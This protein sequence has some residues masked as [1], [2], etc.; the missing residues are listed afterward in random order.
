MF[1]G[2]GGPKS[3]LVAHALREW[4]RCLSPDV[5]PWVSTLDL[6]PGGFWP[7]ELA[8]R[9]EQTRAG[10]LCVTRDNTDSSWLNFEAGAL[11]RSVESALVIPYAIDIDTAMIPTPIGHF[12]GVAANRRDTLRMV[13]RLFESL[14]I[15]YDST[16]GVAEIFWPLL[17]QFLIAVNGLERPDADAMEPLLKTIEDTAV[18]LRTTDLK[19][20]RV[21]PEVAEPGDTLDLEYLIET[22]ARDFPVWL[23]AA[24]CGL[25]GQWFPRVEQ[26]QEITLRGGRRRFSRKLTVDPSIPPGEYDVN[27]EIWIGPKSDSHR[28]YPILRTRRWPVRKIT[29]A[30]PES[31]ALHA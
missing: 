19:D 7:I 15:E 12:Q 5:E 20:V 14:N 8:S 27:A 18:A 1:I 29:V 22:E 3:R 6:Q 21:W 25:E 4:L 24:V 30:P 28:S 23:G 17:H 2:Y 31:R 26:D 11:S 13:S 16:G 9:L 10:I